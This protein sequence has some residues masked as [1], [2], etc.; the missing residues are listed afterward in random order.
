MP[1]GSILNT[2]S[3]HSNYAFR[4]Y[5]QHQVNSAIMPT[6]AMLNT[7]MK[8]F[9]LHEILTSCSLRWNNTLKADAPGEFSLPVRLVLKANYNSSTDSLA[10]KQLNT[11]YFCPSQRGGHDPPIL[12]RS[13][14]KPFSYTFSAV[15]FLEDMC[16]CKRQLTPPPC[17]VLL[18]IHN[19]KLLLI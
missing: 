16:V 4:L 9:V 11:W 3:P 1:S 14:A 8:C 10:G 18:I 2:K 5:T 19:I 6:G 12:K 17:P 15:L 13:T 7:R